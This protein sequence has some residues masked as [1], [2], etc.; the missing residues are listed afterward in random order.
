MTCFTSTK[1]IKI[2]HEDCSRINDYRIKVPDKERVV[3]KPIEDKNKY[4]EHIPAAIGYY[5]KCSYDD[6]ISFYRVYRGEKHM[7][8]F[9]DEMKQ[10]AAVIETVLWC[11][12]DIMQPL[13]VIYMNNH[14]LLTIL[15]CETISTRRQ[16]ETTVVLPH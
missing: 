4:Q 14:S 15:K 1:A 3:L 9:A 2:H 7:Q 13:I 10:L 16:K 5:M 11:T 6:S 8:W 12:Y